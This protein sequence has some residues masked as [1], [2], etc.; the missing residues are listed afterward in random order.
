M[1]IKIW[2]IRRN[3]HCFYRRTSCVRVNIKLYLHVDTKR[4][5]RTLMDAALHYID[6]VCHFKYKNVFNSNEI[7]YDIYLRNGLIIFG[8]R[9]LLEAL[10]FCV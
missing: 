9:P 3:V 7:S 1:N 6:F 10:T 2:G 4:T 5:E 8:S